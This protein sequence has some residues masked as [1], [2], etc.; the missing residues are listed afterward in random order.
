MRY[1]CY[2]SKERLD[3][4]FDQ[5]FEGIVDEIIVDNLWEKT[6]GG[7]FGILQFIKAGLSYGRREATSTQT[8]KRRTAVSRLS[9]VL[10]YLER[11]EKIGDLVS[12]ISQRGVL[13]CDWYSVTADFSVPKWERESQAVYLVA[14]IH[15]YQLK[16]SC[17]KADFSGIHKEGEDDSPTS[18][19]R[20][21]FE[22][23]VALPMSG[24]IR[25]DSV[26]KKQR[27]ILGAPLYLMLNPL[28]V[29]LGEF[30]EVEI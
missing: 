22:G 17:T 19:N 21:L 11:E 14:N 5:A 20:F 18:T 9:S 13:D 29:D 8:R 25:L 6:K 23:K 27:L 2:I 4:L 15:S 3:S 16:L 28:N 12:L 7:N 26:N 10:E 30:N 1:I 24:L